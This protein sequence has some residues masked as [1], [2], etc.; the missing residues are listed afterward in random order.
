MTGLSG[1]ATASPPPSDE[2]L[3]VGSTFLMTLTGTVLLISSSNV[4]LNVG[5]LMGSSSEEELQQLDI[6]NVSHFIV[7]S[8]YLVE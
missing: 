3:A 7:R 8:K 4:L 1:V 5:E 6:I 2:T